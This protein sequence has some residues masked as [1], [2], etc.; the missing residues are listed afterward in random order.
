MRIDF[1]G[2]A[3]LLVRTGT[4]SLLTD[5]WWAGPAYHQQWY[6]YPCPVP[7][8]YDLV[9]LDAIY[10][11]HGHEDHMHEPTL[12]E[13]PKH[14]VVL[15][16]R[17]YDP[18]N[19]D[20]LRELGF[21]NVKELRSGRGFTLRKGSHRLRLT[22]FTSL[23]DSMLALEADDQVAL[24]LN[25]ALHCAR[26]ELIEAYCRV[27]RGRF[28][29]VDY[30]FCGFGGASYFPNC[31]RVPGKDDVAVARKRERQFMEN[32]ALI[33][34]LLQP[35]YAFPFAA[36]FVLP[37]ERNWW[38]SRMRLESDPPA[39]VFAQLRPAARTRCIDLSV[40]DYVEDGV[41]HCAPGAPIEDPE[42]VRFQVLARYRAAP[43]AD[44]NGGI[45]GLVEQMAGNARVR[46][47]RLGRGVEFTA[48]IELWDHRQAAVL[49]RYARGEAEVRLLDRDATAAMQPDL[50]VETGS[51]ILS[52][53]ITQRYGRDHI[54]IGYG[55]II[56]VMS[57][58]VLGSNA[59]EALLD[60]ITPF[61][62]W[63]DH[64]RRHPLRALS[65]LAHDAGMR[66]VLK[67]RLRGVLGGR[68][69]ADTT[70]VNP[71]YDLGNWK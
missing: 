48:L 36:H 71:L 8:R 3:T 59:H 5:P 64:F 66:F 50:I 10:L 12:R 42:S 1:L 70:Q 62:S 40:G 25:D 33:T 63:G 60:L 69:A 26:R 29:H 49:V 52:S 53:A 34:D 30:L 11:S 44:V 57:D 19:R 46:S 13:L 67:S 15:I 55:A 43:R 4:L 39:R 65:Y 17:S 45:A 27:L 32:F 37:S 58:R 18:G 38:I 51:D 24:D 35:D 20:Y 16:A 14:P 61:P 23:T 31:F 41:V 54:C 2:H 47:G 22:I 6:P 21:G 9:A 56:R 68:G 28:R 7:E